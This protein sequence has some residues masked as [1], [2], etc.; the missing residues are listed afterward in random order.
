MKTVHEVSRVAGISVR[1]LHYYDE[2]G[3][4]KPAQTTDV[5]YRLYDHSNFIKLEKILFLREI[6]FALKEIK[7]I[8]EHAENDEEALLRKQRDLLTLQKERLEKLIGIIEERLD[9]GK[10]MNFEAFDAKQ[11]EET[12]KKYH[13]E[14]QARW[15]DTDAYKE[16]EKK[17]NKYSKEEW[18]KVMA[19]G[20]EIFRAFAAYRGEPVSQQEVQALV[21]SWQDHITKNFYTCTNEILAGLGQMYSL[22]E[23][24]TKNID[25]HGEGTAA[26]ITEAIAY[27]V[28][29]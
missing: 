1:T 29:Q 19:D 25:Q 26:Y 7:G 12:K 16:C 8:L 3:L 11:I 2:I 13:D 27:Y 9:G 28:N 6:G 24:F 5:G 23:R 21:K 4:L 17:T 20:N 14:V 15:G 10:Q 22:D 18:A